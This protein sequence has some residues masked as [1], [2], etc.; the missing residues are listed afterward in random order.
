VEFCRTEADKAAFLAQALRQVESGRAIVYCGTRQSSED[1]A[2]ELQ[3]DFAGVGFYHAGLPPDERTRVQEEFSAGRLRILTAT[4]AFGMGI[5][6]PDVR[7]V[8]HHQLPGTLEAYYQEMGRAGRDGLPAT[9]LLLYAKRD[10]SLQTYFIRESLAPA[11]VIRNRWAALDAMIAYAES[12]TCRH[13]GILAYFRDAQRVDRCGHCDVCDPE[14]RQAIPDPV[15]R[16]APRAPRASRRRRE[17]AADLP[18]T[19]DQKAL[20][21]R[22]RAWRHDWAKAND[23]PAFLVFS[24][25]TLRALAGQRPTSPAALR[26]VHGIGPRKIEQF[27]GALLD[28]LGAEK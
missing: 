24:D 13:A 7:L 2:A 9:C 26:A 18:L 23:V 10:K 5:D 8:V 6:H 15:R 25:K 17:D 20:A 11:P 28:V 22:I 14:A 21:D 1:V 12:E 3:R 16:L 19:L 27:G 4:N